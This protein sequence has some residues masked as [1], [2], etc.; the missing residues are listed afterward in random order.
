MRKKWLILLIII[1]ILFP[2]T[3]FSD[4]NSLKSRLNIRMRLSLAGESHLRIVD[5]KS[6]L[7][8]QP[9]FRHQDKKFQS[10]VLKTGPLWETRGWW[11]SCMTEFDV[12]SLFSLKKMK[13]EPQK[14]QLIP[15]LVLKTRIGKWQGL[16]THRYFM[17]LRDKVPKFFY[18][19]IE[20]RRKMRFLGTSYSGGKIISHTISNHPGLYQIDVQI[21]S[22]RR[23]NPL[24]EYTR[25]ILGY[26][27]R[28]EKNKIQPGRIYI[29]IYLFV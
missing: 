18:S 16:I 26:K 28:L 23:Y 22:E 21:I 12:Q 5:K 27:F 14:R 7:G 4:I 15:E 25:L 11:I 19:E 17:P 10:W 3:A 29:S 13:I 24:V 20:F 2:N 6:R 8:A 1:S 9:R